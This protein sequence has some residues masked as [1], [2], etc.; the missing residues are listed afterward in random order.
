MPEGRRTPPSPRSSRKTPTVESVRF[1]DQI[2][3]CFSVDSPTLGVTQ[4][5]RHL[6]VPKARVHRFLISMERVG[7]VRRDPESDR[8]SLGLRLYGLGTVAVNGANY[9]ERISMRAQELSE[10]YGYTAVVGIWSDNEFLAVRTFMPARSL[11]LAVHTGFHSAAH[12]TAQ[13]RVFLAF[14]PDTELEAYL[15]MTELRAL[16]PETLT[17]SDALR[18]ELATIRERCFAVASNQ[19]ALG[20]TAIAAPV[21]DV[22]GQVLA[23]LSLVWFTPELAPRA[24]ELGPA[25]R[26]A[27]LEISA[28]LGFRVSPSRQQ[29]RADAVADEVRR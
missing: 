10:H 11:G 1:L 16:T 20:A 22:Q 6:R 25:L 19:T 23:T 14:L 2:L 9:L 4:I 12:A 8:Y 28:E 13:G 27:G 3:S 17:D 5:A 7:F 15:R 29:L 18:A 26:G 24:A 21:F